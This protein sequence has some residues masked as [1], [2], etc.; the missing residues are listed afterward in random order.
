MGVLRATKR[1]GIAWTAAV[2]VAGA[3]GPESSKR[4]RFGGMDSS[5]NALPGLQPL[6]RTEVLPQSSQLQ[7]WQRVVSESVVPVRCMT[8][9]TFG[10]PA[11]VSSLA[12]GP[13]AH[14]SL[15]RSGPHEVE[16]DGDA[17]YLM[18]II[19]MSGSMEYDH[20][21]VAVEVGPGQARLYDARFKH[22]MIFRDAF[23]QLCFRFPRSW[24]SSMRLP[25]S[26]SL[27]LRRGTGAL[28][29]TYL[30]S[31]TT[32]LAELDPDEVDQA[33]QAAVSLF[34]ESSRRD[35]RASG[36]D[37][38]FAQ[39]CRMIEASVDN[40]VVPTL[41]TVA[42]ASGM[43]QRT[44]T[45]LFAG[46]GET[47][48]GWLMRLRLR[49]AARDLRFDRSAYIGEIAHRWQFADHAHF[50]RS[51]RKHYGTTPK[52]YRDGSG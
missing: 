21:A 11:E 3:S 29:W 22:R 27:E 8:S 5:L 15:V 39:V 46:A 35:G 17:H 1:C 51:F 26:C 12:L 44:L 14:L 13:Q 49:R 6:L 2:S 24:A 18:W 52:S 43:S 25:A 10:F 31:L 36:L 45:G 19:Q 33:S 9:S 42:R 32:G 4:R 50:G 47:F 40:D 41:A 28:A 16:F 7:H 38:R 30:R 20:G 23:T 48:S 37:E 34:A